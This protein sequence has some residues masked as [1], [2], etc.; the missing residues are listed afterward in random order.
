MLIKDFSVLRKVKKIPSVRLNLLFLRTE[1]P[2]KTPL[3]WE[4]L[5]NIRP[6][7]NREDLKFLRVSLGPWPVTVL[8]AKSR[9]T[10]M[11]FV[12]RVVME[13]DK[14]LHPFLML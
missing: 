7:S 1:C 9:L 11:A 13:S 10:N 2:V 3:L 14:S 8:M 12:A 5:W 4:R 6:P